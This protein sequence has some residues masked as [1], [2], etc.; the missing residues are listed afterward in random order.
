MD[1]QPS[2][3][4][5]QRSDPP[6]CG[7]LRV[8]QPNGCPARLCFTDRLVIPQVPNSLF[9]DEI[10]TRRLWKSQRHLKEQIPF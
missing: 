7:D 9:N 5:E 10:V 8:T 4:R 3:F 6:I 2:F 1:T